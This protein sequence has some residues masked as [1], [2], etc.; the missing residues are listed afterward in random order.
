MATVLQ[1]ANLRAGEAGAKKFKSKVGN[2]YLKNANVYLTKNVSGFSGT[3]SLNSSTTDELVG[4]SSFDGT[5]IAGN[6]DHIISGISFGWGG[7]DSNT[8]IQ[9]AAGLHYASTY[10]HP[11]AAAG[12]MSAQL[13]NAELVVTR[14][15]REVFRMPVSSF[16]SMDGNDGGKQGFAVVELQSVE[17][18]GSDDK[19]EI[20]LEFGEGQTVP[21]FASGSVPSCVVRIGLVGLEIQSTKEAK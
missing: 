20:S 18:F 7:E 11:V 17:Y 6:S 8:S 4:V 5:N 9:G 16:I 10:D 2:A 15:V 14:G 19:V 13:F 12:N 3:Q 1:S 21:A